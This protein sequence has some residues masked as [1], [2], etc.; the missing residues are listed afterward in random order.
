MNENSH[1]MSVLACTTFSLFAETQ[2][3]RPNYPIALL[4]LLNKPLKR[5]TVLQYF[6]DVE[7]KQAFVKVQYKNS[8]TR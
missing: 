2:I 7:V 1:M 4:I 6:V 5:S 8:F 3:L